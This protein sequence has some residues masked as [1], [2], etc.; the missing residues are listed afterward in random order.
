[1]FFVVCTKQNDHISSSS[2]LSDEEERIAGIYRYVLN[3][4][5]S[6]EFVRNS[7]IRKGVDDKIVKAVLKGAT[8]FL[9]Q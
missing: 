6:T 3:A 5:V 8:Q 2:L 7:V 1:M 4:Q 9:F